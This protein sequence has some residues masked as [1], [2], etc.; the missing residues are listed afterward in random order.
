MA[1]NHNDQNSALHAKFK[2]IN[3]N[4]LAKELRALSEGSREFDSHR[5]KRLSTIAEQVSTLLLG[6]V[7]WGELNTRYI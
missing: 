5:N 6:R 3:V 7:S 1:D 2:D 4:K